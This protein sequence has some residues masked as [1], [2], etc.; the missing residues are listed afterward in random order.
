MERHRKPVLSVFKQIVE[1]L[2]GIGSRS[3]PA[4]LACRPALAAVHRRINATR[5]GRLSRVAEIFFVVELSKVLGRVKP[6]DR[7]AGNSCE[8]AGPFKSLL[9]GVADVF[10]HKFFWRRAHRP[11]TGGTPLRGL[12]DGHWPVPPRPKTND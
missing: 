6:F 2:I 12:L 10:R 7:H 3:E 4:E 11:A 5:V 8:W 1:A 9:Y